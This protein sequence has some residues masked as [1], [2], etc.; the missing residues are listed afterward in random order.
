MERGHGGGWE[1]K[2]FSPLYPTLPAPKAWSVELK[3]KYT[4]AGGREWEG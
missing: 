3:N 2:S 4:N 1:E